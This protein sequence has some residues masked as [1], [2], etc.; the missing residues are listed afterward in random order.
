MQ[1]S[2]QDEYESSLFKVGAGGVLVWWKYQGAKLS[3]S[4]QSFIFSWICY[5][6]LSKDKI[7][8]LKYYCI[9]SHSFLHVMLGSNA[10]R[11]LNLY[12]E[13]P[14]LH[15]SVCLQTS[16]VCSS[17]PD[18]TDKRRPKGRQGEGPAGMETVQK[19]SLSTGSSQ[20]RVQPCS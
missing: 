9:S 18:L 4:F 13:S 6:K 19:G 3:S 15:H 7:K 17:R 12:K 11:T 5:L 8:N 14:R 1:D 20:V 10:W 2:V 16:C